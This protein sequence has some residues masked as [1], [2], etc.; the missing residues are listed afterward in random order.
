MFKFSD[1]LDEMSYPFI[2][3]AS[4]LCDFEILTDELCTQVGL[5]GSACQPRDRDVQ[6]ILFALQE[7]MFDLNGSIRGRCA[8]DES[9]IDWVKNKLALLR[10]HL[11]ESQDAFFLPRGQ[12]VIVPLHYCRSLS[13]KVTR[14][15]VRVELERAKAVPTTLPRYA[16]CL[17]N[18]F[19]TMAQV[20]NDRDGVHQPVYHSKNY[21]KKTRDEDAGA[22]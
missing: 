4:S 12:G 6:S 10:G 7:K 13:K 8:I 1:D 19:F 2:Y 16:N 15:L 17:T 5:A 11:N 3:E 21:G 18:L 9:D 20:V 14:A 22:C